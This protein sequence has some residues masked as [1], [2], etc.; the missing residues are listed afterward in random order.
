M[1]PVYCV[2]FGIGYW[3]QSGIHSRLVF[4]EKKG[5]MYSLPR[6]QV[7]R[8]TLVCICAHRCCVWAFLNLTCSHS[9][10]PQP[11]AML[12]E[13][14]RETAIIA[15]EWCIFPPARASLGEKRMSSGCHVTSLA[16]GP[17]EAAVSNLVTCHIWPHGG[18]FQRVSTVVPMNDE[19]M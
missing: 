8:W 3:C 2:S 7:G 17:R 5:P 11:F 9:P 6:G 14:I 16:S 12:S 15:W 1:E 10:S 18:D 13:G 19:K 4:G